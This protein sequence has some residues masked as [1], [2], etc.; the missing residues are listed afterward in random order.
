MGLSRLNRV[1]GVLVLIFA[2]IYGWK[3]LFEARRPPCYTV[4]VKYFG[5][6]IRPSNDTEDFSIKP[7]KIPFERSQVDDMIHRV[8][9]TRFYEPQILI[10]NQNVNGSTYGFNRQTAEIIRKYLLDTYDWKKTVQEL[11][12]L[13][14][15][16]TN[17]AVRYFRIFLLNIFF[18]SKGFGYSFR[19]DDT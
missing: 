3:S 10:D 5:Q 7:F 12:N 17:I 14:H 1:I 15:Y 8:R 13:D 16:K 2:I 19:S 18:F 6:A 4:D 11:N 9:E